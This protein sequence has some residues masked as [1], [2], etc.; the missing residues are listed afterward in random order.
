MLGIFATTLFS[1]PTTIF[2]TIS[3]ILCSSFP[4][5]VCRGRYWIKEGVGRT[6]SSQGGSYSADEYA[7]GRTDFSQAGS[8]SSSHDD[9]DHDGETLTAVYKDDMQLSVGDS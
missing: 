1:I 2:S 8:V 6:G 4:S 5:L 7:L 9:D 3:H